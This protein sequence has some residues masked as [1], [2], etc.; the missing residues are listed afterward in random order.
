MK[1]NQSIEHI[2]NL[3]KTPGGLLTFLTEIN[4]PYRWIKVVLPK[5]THFFQKNVVLY[6]NIPQSYG[7]ITVVYSQASKQYV[8][9]FC[10]VCHTKEG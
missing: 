1:G 2:H 10:D 4:K 3:L 7:N 9:N 6:H 8:C 5:V